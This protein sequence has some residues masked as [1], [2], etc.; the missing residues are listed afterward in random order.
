MSLIKT[1]TWCFEKLKSS[2]II[3]D[4]QH[5]SKLKLLK[6]PTNEN[7]TAVIVG[8]YDASTITLQEPITTKLQVEQDYAHQLKNRYINSK[9]H[10]YGYFL[11]NDIKINFKFG[12]NYFKQGVLIETYCSPSALNNPK[13]EI[14]RRLLPFIPTP[15][16]KTHEKGFILFPS[17]YHNYYHWMID[18]LPRIIYLKYLDDKTIPICVGDTISRNAYEALAIALG[19]E[20]RIQVLSG[21]HLFKSAVI[22]TNIS[23]SFDVSKPVITFLRE[24]FSSKSALKNINQNSLPKKIYI[25]RRD[26]NIRRITNE[27]EVIEFLKKRGFSILKLSNI[28][29]LEQATLF[30]NAEVI[31]SHHG[32]ALTNLV[33]CSKNARVVEIFQEGHFNPSFYRIACNLSLDYSFLVGQ[34]IG[35]DTHIDILR[36]NNLLEIK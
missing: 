17:W 34:K 19:D 15:S 7:F 13:Y 29:V 4:V 31:V 22:P 18:I 23:E 33:F 36:L 16:S 6:N 30:K 8:S 25:S 20:S 12:V 27:D 24:T 26:A 32:A 10:V 3:K 21:T 5:S 1:V 14:P 28:S 9:P 35:Y 2:G 11:T